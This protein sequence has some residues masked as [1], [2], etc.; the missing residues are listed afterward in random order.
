MAISDFLIGLFSNPFFLISLFFWI[1]CYILIKILGKRKENVTLLIPFLAMFR[2][3]KLNNLLQRIARKTPRLWKWIWN[4]GI[5]VSFG[6]TI[7]GLYFF[8]SNLIALIT[9]PSIENAI[10]P[11]IPGVTISLPLFS[12]LILPILFVITVHEFSHAMAAG[13]DNITIK[14]TGIFGAGVF[15]VVGFGAFVEI[16][17]FAARSHKVSPWTR[18]RIAGAGTFS[19]AIETVIGLL[20]LLN[21]AAIISPSYGPQVFQVNTVLPT[22][23]GGYNYGNI[24]PGEIV[25]SI[26]GTQINAQ[27]GIDLDSILNNQ[28]SLKCSAGDTLI[29]TSINGNHTDYNRTITLGRHFFLGFEYE[30][31]SNTTA[32]ITTLYSLFQGGNNY[33]NS[34]LSVGTQFTALNGYTFNQTAGRTPSSF[35]TTLNHEQTVNMTL[36]SGEN[37]SI[38]INYFPIV[39][40]AFEFNSFFTGAFFSKLSNTEV[41]VDRVLKNVTENGINEGRLYKGDKIIAVNNINLNLS[42]GKSFENFLINNVG[43]NI[44]SKILVNFTVIPAGSSIPIIRSVYFEPIPKSYVFIGIQSSSYWMQKNWFSS[45]FGGNFPN[46]LQEEFFYFYAVAFSVTLFNMLPIP[47]FDGNRIV[48]EI[49]DKIIG[50]KYERGHKKKLA[51]EFNPKKSDYHL[52]TWNVTEIEDIEM[53]LNEIDKPEFVDDLR[54]KG[55]DTINDGY[56]DTISFDLESTKL[57]PKG[58]ILTATVEYNKDKKERTKKVI[59]WS[60]GIITLTIVALNFILSYV[61][62][63]N[64]TFWMQ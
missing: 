39:Y 42:E 63:G 23:Q 19:N 48:K 64:I 45:L 37:T 14:S 18:L 40:G 2:T 24:S 22:S 16:D 44:T 25:V 11:L 26:N 57:P 17:E 21:F 59:M 4:V 35:L 46:W 10:T 6:F 28:T 62:L 3:K 60:I 36:A 52:M 50:T 8:I 5:F 9:A 58:T 1:F 38:N 33:N 54:F 49:V 12:Y 51:F 55:K 56:I 13:A 20:I 27:N 43:L 53:Q 61:K 47:I 15:F 34:E 32:Q 29:F 7:F 31:V 41:M 30:F